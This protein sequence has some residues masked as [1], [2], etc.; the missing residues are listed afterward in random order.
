[1]SN[2]D[3]KNKSDSKRKLTKLGQEQ[4]HLTGQRL[5]EMIQGIDDKFE[6]CEIKQIRVSD[7]TR[8]KET[9]SI[10]SEYL[11]KSVIREEPDSL[12]NEG[13]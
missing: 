11:P 5:A 7:M 8:A 9:A 2:I 12:L 4:A 1:M 3:E 10:I 13:M 6:A